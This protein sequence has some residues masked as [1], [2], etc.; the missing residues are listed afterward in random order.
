MRVRIDVGAATDVGKVREG[1]EDYYASVRYSS[2][3]PLDLLVVCDGMGGHACGE[4]ASRVACKAIVENILPMRLPDP[5][6]LIYRAVQRAHDEVVQLAQESPDKQGMGTTCVIGLVRD[7]QLYVGNVGDSR[8]YL[9]RKGTVK[10]LSVDQTK[11]QAMVQR[12][13]LSPEEAKI[14][15]D[16]GVLSQAIGQRNEI[17]PYVDEQPAGI[18]LEAGDVVVLCSDGVY[19][20]MVDADLV[21]LTTGDD[22]TRIAQ[23]LVDHAREHDGKDNATAVVARVLPLSRVA[24]TLMDTEVAFPR[25]A[26]SRPP[27]PPSRAPSS[28]AGAK[29]PEDGGG[30]AVAA[31]DDA[32]AG[33][34]PARWIAGAFVAGV[35][36]CGL[37]TL[38]GVHWGIGP[39]K[40]AAATS[41][42]PPSS[43]PAPPASTSASAPSSAAPD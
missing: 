24:R 34:L 13:I 40:A 16:A 9:I 6:E 29:K 8:A 5:R 38:G 32:D 7:G 36:V 4:V 14:H 2:V 22:A 27:P 15:P 12:K 33:R 42:A 26:S 43:A 39:F 1:N 23:A 35:V 18:A 25:S 10:M 21:R 17:D 28:S 20:C 30:A 37:A 3:D 31:T 11:V 19:D 41:S